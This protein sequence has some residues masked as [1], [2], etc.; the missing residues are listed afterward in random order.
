VD[1]CDA[2]LVQRWAAEGLLPTFAGLI[3]TAASM[4]TRA[5]AGFF[6]SALWPSI[7]TATSPGSHHYTN[8]VEL[9]PKT[10][11]LRETSPHEIDGVPFWHTL[12]QQGFRVATVD[13][14][15]AAVHPLRHGTTLNEWG[16]HDRHFGPGSWPTS[17]LADVNERYGPHPVGAIPPA[18]ERQFAPCDYLHRAGEHRTGIENEQLWNDLVE[19][20]RRKAAL[21]L[22][23]LD[24]G[25][26]DLFVSVL[27]EAHCAGHQ[28]WHVHDPL[29]PRHDPAVAARLGDPILEM[30]RLLD[31]TVGEHLSRLGP[32]TT[33]YV[34]LTH[35]MGPHYDGC[36]LLEHVLRR[37]EDGTHDDVA[38]PSLSPEAVSGADRKDRRWFTSPN[39]T[40]TGAIR[41]NLQGRE[42]HGTVPAGQAFDEACDQL[43]EWLHELVDADTGNPVVTGVHRTT[44]HYARFDGD[45][46]PDLLVEWNR[47]RPIERVRSPRIGTI[48]VPYTHWRTGDHHDRGLLLAKGPGITPGH[49]R[50]VASAIDIAPTLTAA[51][52]GHLPRAEGVPLEG[53]VPR[54]RTAVR[55]ASG[56]LPTR[57][58]AREFV[59]IRLLALLDIPTIEQRLDRAEGELRLLSRAHHETRRDATDALAAGV[60]AE[61]A[62]AT[63]SPATPI[64][65]DQRTATLVRLAAIDTTTKWVELA[66][67]QPSTLVSVVMPTYNRATL[68]PR[69]IQSVLEQQHENWELIIV[70]DGSTDDTAAVL[71]ALADPRIRCLSKP[72]TGCCASRNAALDVAKGDAIAYLDDDNV[73][74][75]LWLKAVAWA[76]EQRPD[77]DVLHGARLIDD[78]L[79]V[80]D[81]DTSGGLPWVQFEPY[82]R[83]RLEASNTS[84]MGVLAHRAGVPEAHF[85]EDLVH[86]GDW[87]LFLRL[88][89]DKDPLEL[90]VIAV[91][92]TT[93]GRDRLS[94][95]SSLEE[96]DLI[97]DK[98]RR[99]RGMDAPG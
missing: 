24:Q 33:V 73:M 38:L 72:H 64:L 57:A 95:T 97:T 91:A 65:D 20:Q 71:D 98:L 66:N 77:V 80:H 53:F 11:D 42:P 32:E 36:H 85:D 83:A 49:R 14:P 96:L 50:A 62:T 44:D 28:F 1:A 93:D 81:P 19:G 79:R 87:D 21:S 52:G 29:H 43:S 74:L 2:E 37:L 59:R 84:D 69:A 55:R 12:D 56:R 89:A 4:G 9:D 51:V 17:F 35:G 63:R 88:T 8:W 7:V 22:D 75:P 5:P 15:H 6:V 90:P 48:D 3:E 82:D 30:Y 13:V 10:Y 61:A 25:G 99:P 54:E 58:E 94:R 39:N 76:F 27:G 70:D 41:I 47:T 46:F 45:S 60:R 23:L 18:G 34:H 16:C 68:L 92:Y 78:Y 40:V 31:H 86:F 26:W 67:V